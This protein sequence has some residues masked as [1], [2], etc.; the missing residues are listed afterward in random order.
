MRHHKRQHITLGLLMIL[1]CLFA[2]T[3]SA[4]SLSLQMTAEYD[5]GF[6]CPVSSTLNPD[7]TALWVLM[8][9]CGTAGYSLHAF[10]PVDGTPLSEANRSFA[11]VLAPLDDA[12]FYG[13]SP[14]AFTPDGVL[15]IFYNAGDDYDLL[16]VRVALD[17]AAAAAPSAFQ[18]NLET[19][20]EL[21]PGY[22]GYLE[23][24]AYNADHTAAAV[25]DTFA[26]HIIDLQT[27]A[28]ILKMDEPDGTEITFPSFSQDGQRLY[29][30][31][32]DNPD[33]YEDYSGA[34]SIYS[35]PDGALLQTHAVPSAL[36]WVSPNEQY[37]A[38][39]IGSSTGDGDVLGV[40]ELATGAVSPTLPINEPPSKLMVCAND[41]R[42]M[43]DVDFTKSG[44]LPLRGLN[45]L[46]DNSG[47]FT[48]NSYGGEAA[49]GGRPCFFN[50][51]R[52]RQYRVG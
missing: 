13:S 16:N 39:I 48:V 21:I 44:R 15:D 35:L 31:R 30:A 10:N 43:S 4:Q 2:L 52:M 5:I 46:P 17:S 45:W 23:T 36:L 9:N 29:I 50:Y 22:E 34:L 11:D 47:F 26:Y 14:V 37:A 27:G 3:A 40:V 25:M 33:D 12:Y 24:T 7:A 1:L 20:N 42:D 8:N 6:D 41:G 19:V 38:F 49:G 32:F 18:L 28:E 51:S